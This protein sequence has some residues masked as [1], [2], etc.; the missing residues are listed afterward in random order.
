MILLPTAYLGNLQYYSK[1]LSGE[2]C[3]DLHEHYLKQSYRNRCDIL[4]AGGVMSLTVPVYHT[5]GVGTPTREIRIDYSK[6]WQ[7]R[8]WQAIV[9]AYR[10]SPYFAHYEEHFA[11]LYRQRFD[12]LT[13]LNDTLQRTVLHL[14]DPSGGAAARIG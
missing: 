8:H 1:L 3:I 5:G 10:G 14:L 12:L 6:R 13:E 11:P 7:H 9:S 2:A 4:S